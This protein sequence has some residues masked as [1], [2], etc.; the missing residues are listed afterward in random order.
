MF[1]SRLLP[2]FTPFNTMVAKN[3]KNL[4]VT[5]DMVTFAGFGI[6]MLS[7][8][9]IAL[10]MYKAALALICFS[11]IADGVD[12][13]LARM[14]KPTDSGGFID[15]VCDFIFY[16]AI[17]FAFALADPS[18]NGLAAT[19]LIFTFVGTGSSFLTY[20]IFAAKY[21]VTENFKPQMRD[22][23]KQS[24]FYFLGGLTEGTETLLFFFLICL[25]PGIFHIAAWIFGVLCLITTVTRIYDG[26]H[27]F[28]S[29]NLAE[30][31]KKE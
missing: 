24:S 16:G 12:G 6:G 1:D 13:C 10:G 21:G 19:F 5:P 22:D 15:I 2:L 29:D 7:V 27:D 30:A 9:L 18:K 3:L 4:G 17:P 31:K 28:K 14:G 8:P 23:K 11:R 20:A 25:F 26:Y